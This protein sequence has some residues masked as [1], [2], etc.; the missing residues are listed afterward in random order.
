MIDGECSS[1]CSAAATDK[2]AARLHSH[3][4]PATVLLSISYMSVWR[5]LLV[6]RI[7]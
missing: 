3:T 5:L 2:H 7:R 1:E 4:S 6:E